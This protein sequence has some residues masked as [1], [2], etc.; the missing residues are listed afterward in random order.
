MSTS[1]SFLRDPSYGST[2]VLFVL[3]PPGIPFD[4]EE[5]GRNLYGKRPFTMDA[6]TLPGM[7]PKNGFRFND[8]ALHWPDFLALAFQHCDHALFFI[9]GKQRFQEIRRESLLQQNPDLYAFSFYRITCESYVPEPAEEQPAARASAPGPAHGNADGKARF[10][11]A[12]KVLLTLIDAGW[13]ANAVAKATD[14]NPM[15]IGNIRNE[16]QDS[17]SQRVHDA[18]LRLN[19]DVAAGTATPTDGRRRNGAKS[20]SVKPATTKPPTTAAPPSVNA[21]GSEARY[22]AV[23][24]ALLDD[25]LARLMT[26]FTGAIEDLEQMKKLI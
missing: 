12:R 13:S 18:L 24:A 20:A 7:S 16:K 11:E 23:D 17:V 1:I 9:P 10:A 3:S 8:I 2:L 21:A 4:T 26:T 22:V 5:I 19:A 25:L 14:I 15:T 6:I